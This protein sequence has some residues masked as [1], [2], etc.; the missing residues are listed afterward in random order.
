MKLHRLRRT[1]IVGGLGAG[2][3]AGTLT[4]CASEDNDSGGDGEAAACAVPE[5]RRVDAA[6][7][8][9]S[10]PT[11][12][13]NPLFPR[14]PSGQAIELG[15]EKDERLRT[16]VTY[17]PEVK[18][19][20]WDGMS[21]DTRVTHFVAYKDGRI[22]ETALDFY[23]QDDA[24]NVW[25]FGEDVS[26]YEDGVVIDHEGTWLAGRDGPP[27]MIMPAQ[28]QVGDV[29]RPE[30]VPDLVF[31]EVTVKAADQTVQGPRGP[32]TGAV[33]VQECLMDGTLEDKQY[34]PGYGEFHAAVAADDEAYSVAV[35]VPVDS[36]PGPAPAGLAQLVPQAEAVSAAVPNGNWE[37]L[38]ASVAALADTWDGARAGA[39]PLLEAQ[40]DGALKVL[41]DAVDRRN[42]D[43]AREAAINVGQ[44]GLDLLLPYS[45]QAE[46]DRARLGLWEDQLELD[47]TAG[48]PGDV[49]GDLVTIDAIKARI[50]T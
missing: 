43:D 14:G 12:I 47:R 37:Q 39:P 16:E 25:Y 44:A 49:E 7:P 17:L 41:T 33:F 2:L 29:F 46:I 31:E 5:A 20:N 34:A 38:S 10:N 26:N 35:A 30:N 4:A 32:V 15:A 3:L 42:A 21:I 50:P 48:D 9:F 19:V 11:S 24:G 27:G 45:P 1:V 23:A 13:T 6:R 28:P 36:L 40:M 22:A 18:A 8:T